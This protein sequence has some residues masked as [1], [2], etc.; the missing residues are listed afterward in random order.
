MKYNISV[1]FKW[2]ASIISAI[3]ISW[4]ALL[5]KPLLDLIL[6]CMKRPHL[7][8]G[9]KIA[10]ISSYIGNTFMAFYFSGVSLN[11]LKPELYSQRCSFVDRVSEQ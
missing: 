6:V 2:S 1:R 8:Y 11:K 3:L 4:E 10:G 7:L 9:L 5:R